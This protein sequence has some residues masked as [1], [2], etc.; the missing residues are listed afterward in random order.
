MAKVNLVELPAFKLM[1][2]HG[3]NWTALR[4][5]DP[6]GSKQIIAAQLE[7]GGFEVEVVNL[8]NS[9]RETVLGEV[10]WRGQKLTKIA[11]GIPWTKLDPLDADV[12]GVTVNY[13]FSSSAVSGE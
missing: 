7:H 10:E 8:K 13:C 11:V 4:R 2:P 6:I 3:Q 12:W 1:D 9:E 5:L